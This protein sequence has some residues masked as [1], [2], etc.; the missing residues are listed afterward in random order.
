MINSTLE[1]LLS[2]R[3]IPSKILGDL[4]SIIAQQTNLT[5]RWTKRLPNSSKQFVLQ[6]LLAFPITDQ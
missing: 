1:I 3:L 2:V 5:G 6:A 4:G